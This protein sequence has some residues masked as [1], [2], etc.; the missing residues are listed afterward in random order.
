MRK[1]LFVLI[2]AVAA[3]WSLS[4]CGDSTAATP[5]TEEQ[6]T[7]A[8][9]DNDGI[10]EP[11]YADKKTMLK[12]AEEAQPLSADT[13]TVG[14]KVHDFTLRTYDGGTFGTADMKGKVTLLVFFFPT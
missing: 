2:L 12:L 10:Y 9:Q 13:G 7:Y 3:V 1:H 4:A 6:P 8:E 5:K 14:S 11:Q